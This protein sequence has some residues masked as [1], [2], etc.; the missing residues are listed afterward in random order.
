MK[1]QQIFSE[2]M[3]CIVLNLKTYQN[4]RI[5]EIITITNRGAFK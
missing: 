4:T 3:K 2:Y 1:P 5:P